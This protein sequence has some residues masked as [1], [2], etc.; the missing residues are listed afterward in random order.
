MRRQGRRQR[1]AQARESTGGTA[2]ACAQHIEHRL[3]GM[4]VPPRIS[5]E[6]RTVQEMANV[7]SGRLPAWSLS[8]GWSVH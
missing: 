7:R 3:A 4:E 5:R 1:I 8:P 2:D 6:A